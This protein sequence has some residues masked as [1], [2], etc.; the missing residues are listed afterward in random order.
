[1]ELSGALPIAC[2][3]V[4]RLYPGSAHP[5]VDRATFQVEAGKLVVLLGP[6]GC[7]K[8][9][10]LKM[11][12]RLVEPTSGEIHI[13]GIEI[14]DLPPVQLRRHIGYVIQQV[15][16]FPHMTISQNIGVVPSL[17]GWDAPRIQA[18]SQH[19]LEMVGLPADYLKRFP[20]QLSGGEQQR[21]GLARALAADPG[22]LL[23][24]EPFAAIDAI[25]RLRMQ[26]ELLDIQRKVQ[27]TI[28][29]VTHDVEEALRLADRIVVM[30][31]GQIV[32]YA[33]PLE[34]IT[35]PANDFVRELAGSGDVLRR[36]SVI[37][38]GS[39]LQETRQKSPPSTNLESE[40]ISA[41]LHESLRSVL[42]RMID[43]GAEWLQLVDD[44]GQPLKRFRFEDLRA[45]LA[46]QA[47]SPV[48]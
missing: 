47:S 9:T 2:D 6:S 26:N 21:V 7:G 18:R 17:I 22:I 13:G 14:H 8:T 12:N 23:M 19:L 31:S 34:V 29:F 30:R 46:Q 20:R 28:L 1:M 37:E 5:A 39:L 4:T 32:Q 44:H 42:S 10:L 3:Q 24:D 35:R 38:A 11:I 43:S 16:L 27:K 45:V 41:N 40:V 48:E 25:T 15:G 36:L 33:S